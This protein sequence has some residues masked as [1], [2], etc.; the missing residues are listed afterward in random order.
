MAEDTTTSTLGRAIAIAYGLIV[1]PCAFL[2]L[3]LVYN[4]AIWIAAISFLLSL[5][6]SFLIVAAAACL[7]HVAQWTEPLVMNG[8][9]IHVS[10]LVVAI[11]MAYT[12]LWVAM[13]YGFVYS[14]FLVILFAFHSRMIAELRKRCENGVSKPG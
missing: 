13:S 10:V 1:A 8:L 11:I 5:L 3:Y 9:A 2:S 4:D 12:G 7:F 14:A 6:L